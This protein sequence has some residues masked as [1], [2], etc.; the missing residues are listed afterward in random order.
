M[1]RQLE[2]ARRAPPVARLAADAAGLPLGALLA[3]LAAARGGKAFHPAGAVHAATLRVHGVPSAPPAELLRTPAAHAALVRFSRSL[4]LPRPLPDLL[5]MSVRLPDVHGPGAHQDLLLVS[6]ADL[7]VLHHLFLPAGDV[8]R[9]PY[10]SALPYRAGGE[11]VLLGALPDPDSPRPAGEDELVRLAAAARTGKLRFRLAVAGVGGRFR[12]VA[13]LEVGERLGDPLDALRFNPWNTG[14][15]LEP[16]G[17]LN[18]ARAWAYPLSQAAWG[19][20]ARH[21]DGAPAA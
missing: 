16:A 5:G 12:P 15:G 8:Q 6:S 10:T 17:W 19:R 4:G 9:R 13:T 2:R 18:R 21:G 14:G 7:P 1:R 20:A 11:L 3:L